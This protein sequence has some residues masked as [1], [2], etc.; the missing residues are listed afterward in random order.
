MVPAHAGHT[1]D[2]AP[3]IEAAASGASCALDVDELFQD[4]L[5]LNEIPRMLRRFIDV[6]V[7][8]RDFVEQY[9][10]RLG[11]RCLRRPA[12]VVLPTSPRALIR[13]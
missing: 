11:A 6:L 1:I 5:H 12:Q 13:E 7:C 3:F 9:F 10:R 4:V 2:P 8:G